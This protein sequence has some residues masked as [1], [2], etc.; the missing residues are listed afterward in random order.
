M[1]IERYSRNQSNLQKR[2]RRGHDDDVKVQQKPV[3]S[4]EEI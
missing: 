3:Q 1:M 2:Y 4:A